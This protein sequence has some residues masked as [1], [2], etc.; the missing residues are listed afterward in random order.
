GLLVGGLCLSLAGETRAQELDA[1]TAAR[2]RF[3]SFAVRNLAPSPAEAKA[4]ASGETTVPALIE[5]WLQEPSHT[6]KVREFFWELFGTQDFNMEPGWRVK[7]DENGVYYAVERGSCDTGST[8]VTAWW[9]EK[10]V[11]MCANIVSDAWT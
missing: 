1:Q 5:K 7:K 10:A 6:A 4:V 3:A 11:K 8:S 2:L 9:S